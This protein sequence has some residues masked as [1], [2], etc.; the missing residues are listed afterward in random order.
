MCKVLQIFNK[1]LYR[2]DIIIWMGD[3]NYRINKKLEDIND[4]LRNKDEN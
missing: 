1:L 3:F 2:Y 4:I